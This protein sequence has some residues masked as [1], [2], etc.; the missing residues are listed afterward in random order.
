MKDSLLIN[1][2]SAQRSEGTANDHR[3]HWQTQFSREINMP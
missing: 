1:H 3:G 2:P